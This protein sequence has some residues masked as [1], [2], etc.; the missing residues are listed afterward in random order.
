MSR[1]RIELNAAGISEMLRSPGVRADLQRR[2]EAVASA[3]RASAP[4]QTGAYRDSIEVEMTTAADLG[5]AFRFG[6]NDR[7][8]AI[9]NASAR[10]APLVES[11]TGNLARALNA[12]GGA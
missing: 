11:R 2:A 5:I 3:A 9:V 1:P 6:G 7:P 10:H 4:V 12:A 8:A